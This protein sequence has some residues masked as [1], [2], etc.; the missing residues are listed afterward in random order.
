MEDGLQ[1]A[2]RW[3]ALVVVIY[4]ESV[5][6]ARFGN[7]ALT[8][9]ECSCL[10]VRLSKVSGDAVLSSAKTG[11]TRSALSSKN[12]KET[13]LRR[14]VAVS[15]SLTLGVPLTSAVRIP[16]VLI[17]CAL[18]RHCWAMIRLGNDTDDFW[19][20]IPEFG[21]CR[22]QIDLNGRWRK[23]LIS[24]AYTQENHNL[25]TLFDDACL[26]HVYLFFVDLFGTRESLGSKVLEKF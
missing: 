23:T 25:K 11:L 21:K 18:W 3:D 24:A 5:Q 4:S 7:I 19:L 2:E 8:L 15:S 1:R 26:H 17:D 22:E 10:E 9:L 14:R 6:L 13:Y 16:Y 20:C 12:R